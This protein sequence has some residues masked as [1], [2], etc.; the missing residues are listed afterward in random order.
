MG[1]SLAID[2]NGKV[3]KHGMEDY[4]KEGHWLGVYPLLCS[5]WKDILPWSGPQFIKYRM[6][7]FADKGL[8]SEAGYTVRRH[9]G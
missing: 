1:K 3:L 8:F 9:L 2:I 6:T 7:E 4:I 5:S